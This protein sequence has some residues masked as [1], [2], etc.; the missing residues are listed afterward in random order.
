NVRVIGHQHGASGFSRPKELR[1]LEAERAHKI[2]VV[3]LG[4]GDKSKDENELREALSILSTK[5]KRHSPEQHTFARARFRHAAVSTLMGGKATHHVAHKTNM[6]DVVARVQTITDAIKQG[7]P[8][9]GDVLGKFT[10][11]TDRYAVLESAGHLTID[12]LFHRQLIGRKSILNGLHP[13]ASSD[14]DPQ[15]GKCSLGVVTVDYETRE[16]SAKAGKDFK[17]T[18]G[19]LTFNEN[20]YRKTIQIPIIN[21]DQYEADVDFYVILKNPGGGAGLGDPNITRITVVDDDEPGEFLFE[22]HH[23]HADMKKGKADVR[24]V[25]EHGFDGTVTLE[26]S[27]IPGTAKGGSTL[28]PNVDFV[29]SH[30]T[31]SFDHGETS[32]IITININRK[33]EESKNFIVALRNPSLGAKIGIRSAAVIHLNHKDELLERV[34]E[35]L[36]ENKEEDVTWGGQFVEAMTVSNDEKDE[37]GN[38]I[39]VTW[40]NYVMHFLTFFWK[41]LCACIPPTYIWGAWPSFL[42]SL[43]VIGTITAFIEQ[44]GG[45]LGCVTGLKT[46]VTGITLIAL[47]TSL[48]DTFA[49]RTAAVQDEHADAAIGNITGSNSVNV[50]LGLGLPWVLSTMYKLAKGKTHK[51]LEGNLAFSVYVY[52][53]LAVITVVAILLRRKMSGGELGGKSLPGKVLFA[54]FLA[55]MWVIYIILSSLKAYD[56][57]PF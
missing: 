19:S 6:S 4:H 35:I 5:E 52:T 53:I 44:L 12:V 56:Q 32:K 29:E 55:S 26:Y 46:S 21:D 39:E 11:G 54:T 43:F 16:G 33:M 7:K 57:L 9:V 25:R 18:Q 24:V 20:E 27:T 1:V 50:F 37:D 41:I 38:E 23:Y 47:G 31:L 40:V 30:G 42:A 34:G 3:T 13:T 14:V 10:F 45:L 28:G 15:S 51:V 36:E 49:S 17:Y 8:P 48:P 22:Q 2:S